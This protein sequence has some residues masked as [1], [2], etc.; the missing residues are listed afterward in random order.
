MG[1]EETRVGDVA[2]TAIVGRLDS[3]TSPAYE[4]DLMKLPEDG[5]KALVLDLAEVD[6]LSSA[7]IRIL[8]MLFKRAAAAGIPVALARPQPHV[9][10]ILDI[11]GLSDVLKVYPSV[12]LAIKAIAA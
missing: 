7:G 8:V 11:A 2:V 1:I 5:R 3:A 6:Y 10:E 12:D 9:A 4:T